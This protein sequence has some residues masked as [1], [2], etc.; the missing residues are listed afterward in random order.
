MKNSLLKK[1]SFITIRFLICLFGY[2][3]VYASSPFEVPTL[4]VLGSEEWVKAKVKTYPELEWLLDSNV[5][6]TQEGTVER[7]PH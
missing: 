2:N 7:F 5:Q 4:E 6:H 1:F 3:F